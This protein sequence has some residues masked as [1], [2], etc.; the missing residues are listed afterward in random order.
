[1]EEN[2]NKKWWQSLD[3]ELNEADQQA[4]E[5]EMEADP[6]QAIAFSQAK[7]I[8]DGLQQLEADEPSMRFNKNVLENLPQLY[9]K[10]SIEPFFA[11]RVLRRVALLI[12]SLGLISLL[13][14]FFIDSNS[15]NAY[16]N[17][18]L[19]FLQLSGDLPTNWM[20]MLAVLGFGFIVYAI[21]DRQLKKRILKGQK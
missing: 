19:D 6:T 9:K 13:P 21:M 20:F 2:F 10:I 3:K 18:L 4:F 1:M 14:A 5:K 16:P 8:H 7:E 12:G 11:P 15:A 17:I